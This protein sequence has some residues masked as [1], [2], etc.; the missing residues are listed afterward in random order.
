MT[1]SHIAKRAEKLVID[2]SPAILTALGITGT[3]TM[4]YLTG[5]ASIKANNIIKDEQYR[6]NLNTKPHEKSHVLDRKEKLQLTWK[7]YIPTVGTGVLTIACII[8]ANRIGNRRAA[9]LATAYTVS[10]KAFTE[11]KEKVVDRFGANKERDVRDSVAQD[12][13]DQNPLGGREVI[14]AGSGDVLC[15]DCYTDRYFQSSMEELKKAQNDLN[16][17]LITDTVASLSDFYNKLGLSPTSFSDDVGWTSSNLLEIDY[18][19]T[20]SID[21]RPCISITFRVEPIRGYN[22]LS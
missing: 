3:L 21:G 10:E 16:Y 5:T 18:S 9:A 15:Y 1:L 7:L 6:L 20:L 22:K 14:I 13:V 8:C 12:R 4:A 2:N 17:M 11:Y 19:T